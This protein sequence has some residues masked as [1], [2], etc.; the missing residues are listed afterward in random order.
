MNA[1][2]ESLYHVLEALKG[3]VLNEFK[4]YSDK[5]LQFRPDAESWNLLQVLEHLVLAEK[6]TLLSIRKGLSRGDRVRNQSAGSKLRMMA[7][8][9]ALFLPLK[10][11]AP[12]MVEVGNSGKG[13]REL[14]K[15]W[16]IVREQIRE[17]LAGANEEA[18]RKELFLHPRAGMLTIPQALDFLKSHLQHHQKQI[19]SIK[20][21][22]NFPL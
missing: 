10:F 19:E 22:Q 5:Q 20:S 7:L 21:H 2:T 12:K 8:K 16:D 3:S 13:F 9:I 4:N 17:L 1:Q 18:L 6:M 11:K 15:D 14:S